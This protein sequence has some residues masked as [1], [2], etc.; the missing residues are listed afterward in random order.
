MKVELGSNFCLKIFFSVEDKPLPGLQ[1]GFLKSDE[2][3]ILYDF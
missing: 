3:A 2:N 1:H